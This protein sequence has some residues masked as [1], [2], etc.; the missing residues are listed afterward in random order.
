[1]TYQQQLIDI[2]NFELSFL[3][4]RIAKLDK[5]DPKLYINIKSSNLA[6]ANCARALIYFI[7]T[8]SDGTMVVR[9]VDVPTS[10]LVEGGANTFA[11]V[12]LDTELNEKFTYEELSRG[13]YPIGA[14]IEVGTTLTA[15]AASTFACSTVQITKT[16]LSAQASMCNSTLL[17]KKTLQTCSGAA[18]GTLNFL[19]ARKWPQAGFTT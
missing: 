6:A 14:D 9:A 3:K 17:G 8:Q 7:V 2:P 12:T 18:A 13:V 4:S 1:M 10:D 5:D 16:S 19:S 11:Q 15:S